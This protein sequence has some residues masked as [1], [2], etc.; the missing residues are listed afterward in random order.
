MNTSHNGLLILA[1]SAALSLAPV[2]PTA[3]GELAAKTAQPVG[4]IERGEAKKAGALLDRAVEL[5]QKSGPQAAFAA[6]NDRKGDFVSGPYY[7][8]VVGMEG[9]MHANG[10]APD[11]LVGKNMLDLRDAAGKPLIRELLD[12]AKRKDSGAI[13]YHWLNRANNRVENKTT[14]FRKVGSQVVAVGYYLPRSTV[15]QA[16]ELLG[17]AVDEVK[18]AGAGAAIKA[19]NDPK[20]R[21]IRGDLYV[22]AIGLDDGNYRASGA[23]PQLSGQ[24]ASELHDAAGK[25]MIQEMIALAKKQGKGQVSYVWLNPATNAVEPKHS[26]IQRVDDMLLGVGYYEK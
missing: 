7:V 8:Y 17:K 23:V 1:C 4:S 3:A 20:G 24:N 5:L 10:G 14:L 12:A 26:V 21:F 16:K 2:L 15:E 6:F 25:P 19:F 11:V 9:I 22:F 18:K 13:E